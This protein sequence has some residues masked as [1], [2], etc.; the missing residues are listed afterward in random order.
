MASRRLTR[1][2]QRRTLSKVQLAAL[3]AKKRGS[4]SPAP[5]VRSKPRPPT[6]DDEFLMGQGGFPSDFKR[7]EEF[8]TVES[9]R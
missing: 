9:V 4:G 1:A 6:D 7:E 3:F 5:N 2:G 8:E